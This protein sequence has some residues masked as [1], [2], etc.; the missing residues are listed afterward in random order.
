MDEAAAKAHFLKLPEAWEDFPFGPDVAVFKIGRKMFGTLARRGD[1]PNIN[2]KCD[3]AEALA[4]RD[5][6]AAVKPG[7][8]MNKVHWNT[9]DLD[10]S[11]PSPEVARMIDNSYGLVV[12]TLPRAERDALVLRHGRDA[13]FR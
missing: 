6:F 3:P 8:H 12:K 13:V 9:V 11:V 1:M 7:Y 4:L 10:G 5:I 2:L